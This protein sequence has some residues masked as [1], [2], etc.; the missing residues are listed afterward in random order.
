MRLG[1][2]SVLRHVLRAARHPAEQFDVLG[3]AAN[4]ALKLGLRR[5]DL[6]E[7]RLDLLDRPPA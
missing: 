2:C 7:E 4:P 6:A 3:G 1:H 5:P